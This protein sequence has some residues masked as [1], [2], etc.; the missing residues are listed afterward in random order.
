MVNYTVKILNDQ[1]SF[2]L[3]WTTKYEAKDEAVF[4]INSKEVMLRYLNMF[5]LDA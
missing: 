4:L 1:S 3:S 2:R 5:T